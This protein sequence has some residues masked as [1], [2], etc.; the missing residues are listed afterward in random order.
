MVDFV[1]R[2]HVERKSNSGHSKLQAL[3][4]TRRAMQAG[5]ENAKRSVTPTLRRLRSTRA[6]AWKG[7]ER[8][9]ACCANLHRIAIDIKI[10][11]CQ[12]AAL[13]WGWPPGGGALDPRWPPVVGRREARGARAQPSKAGRQRPTQTPSNI[14]PP[15]LTLISALFPT[16]IHPT[17]LTPRTPIGRQLEMSFVENP[18]GGAVVTS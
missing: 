3:E 10:F 7:G 18:G 9:R 5:G 17:Q 12:A 14:T 2:E 15:S 4:T 16:L 11:L 13:A 1:G 8:C 6:P